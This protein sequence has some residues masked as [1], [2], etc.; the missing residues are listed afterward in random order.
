[1]A[2][3]LAPNYIGS[4]G[5]LTPVENDRWLVKTLFDRQGV[6]KQADFNVTPGTG[7]TVNIA[8]GA[9][10]V[11]G[12]EN[13]SQGGYYVYSPA[14]EVLSWPGPS[15]SAR[16]D[17]LILQIVD[18]QYGSSALAEGAQWIIIAGTP[19][20]SPTAPTDSDINAVFR[21]GGWIR[22]ANVRI[23]VGDVTV[24]PANIT[25][26]RTFALAPGK[27]LAAVNLA[28][29]PTTSLEVGTFGYAKDTNKIY[30]WNGT[31]WVSYQAGGYV[32]AFI[33]AD[34]T[35]TNTGATAAG[36]TIVSA[37]SD[38]NW[39]ITS[40]N[41]LTPGVGVA[42]YWQFFI[43]SR[44]SNT[45]VANG[46]LC[47]A[48]AQFA[49]SSG[50]IASVGGA[51]ATSG[52]SDGSGASMAYDIA[53]IQYLTVRGFTSG[54]TATFWQRNWASTAAGGDGVA[55]NQGYATKITGVRI[56]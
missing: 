53:T 30:Y 47:R 12:K 38:A 37:T 36:L 14:T 25:M 49:S 40:S 55:G 44:W 50:A 56:K 19:S 6:V 13:V 41:R 28:A 31:A 21:P 17:A 54:A 29:L 43:S 4:A 34:F 23:N 22:I 8:A 15:A 11:L 39:S 5:Y 27:P 51:G 26:T 7:L 45:T 1:M 42:G 3:Q 10:Y 2:L 52:E 9:A 48:I 35:S 20:G 33:N 18:K 16:I 24:N 32:E 46:G